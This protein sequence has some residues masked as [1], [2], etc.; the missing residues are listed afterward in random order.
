MTFP[1]LSCAWRSAASI[2]AVQPE[3]RLEPIDSPVGQRLMAA[4]HEDVTRVYP[5]WTP[6]TGPS[7]DPQ[8]MK[9]PD[10]A[11]LVACADGEAVGCGGFKRLDERTAEIKRMFVAA[12][13]RGRGIGRQ[14]LERLE[15][16]AREAGYELARLDTG[17]R[18]P[19]ALHI[20]RSAG[21]REIPDYNGNPAASYWFEKPLR[22]R[23]NL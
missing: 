23:N 8:E 17:D 2:A 9:P 4:F 15:Q 10:G 20:Y 16:E 6:T 5:D 18:Q 14:I 7:V 13:V 21:Y 3:F 1:N 11:F 12:E 19:D 22:L